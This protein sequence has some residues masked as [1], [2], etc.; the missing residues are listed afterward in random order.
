VLGEGA[1]A[2]DE[3]GDASVLVDGSDSASIANGIA[4]AVSLDQS[5]RRIMARRRADAVRSWTSHHW[6]SDFERRLL[7]ARVSDRHQIG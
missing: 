6:A 1:G 7:D 3:L 5:T 4:R 2:A